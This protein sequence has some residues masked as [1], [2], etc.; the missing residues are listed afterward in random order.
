MI[1][2]LTHINRDE[3]EKPNDSSFG[4]ALNYVSDPP[5]ENQFDGTYKGNQSTTL[6]LEGYQLMTDVSPPKLYVT[7]GLLHHINP[8]S[9]F[10]TC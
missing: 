4:L 10:D 8:R 3:M 9:S 1:T 7:R 2:V 5:G 6:E